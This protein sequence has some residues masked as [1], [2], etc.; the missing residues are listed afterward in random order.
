MFLHRRR[1]ASGMSIYFDRLDG[2]HEKPVDV[3]ATW[4][5]SGYGLLENEKGE[6]LMVRSAWTKRLDL[7]GGGVDAD[8]SLFEG[9]KRE[10]F[11]E[12]GFRVEVEGGPLY[13]SEENYYDD[14][15]NLFHHAMIIIYRVKL[16]DGGHD[17]RVVNTTEGYEI[18]SQMWVDPSTLTKDGVQPIFWPFVEQVRTKQGTG[19]SV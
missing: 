15:K 13:L 4:R 1:K 14:K 12:T 17:P 11:E 10:V 5:I 18:E 16:A 6:W 9:I 2:E 19:T 3:E 8:E 7:P